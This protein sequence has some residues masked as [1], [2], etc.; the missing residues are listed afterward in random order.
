[1]TWLVSLGTGLIT[2]VLG[3]VALGFLADRWTVWFR[4]SNFEGAAGY[5]VLLYGLVGAVGG[6]IIGVVCSRHVVQGAEAH[7]GRGLGLSVGWVVGIVGCLAVVSYLAADHPPRRDGRRLSLE[8]ELRAPATAVLSDKDGTRPMF[9]LEN[10]RGRTMG[11]GVPATNEVRRV[12]DG[13]EVA[14]V[15]PLDSSSASRTLRV[16]VREGASMTFPLPLPSQPAEADFSWTEWIAPGASWT[17]AGKADASLGEGFRLRCRVAFRAVPPPPPTAEEVGR[18]KAGAEAGALAAVPVDAPLR[19]WLPFTRYGVSE[20][21]QE[22]A[23]ARMRGRSNVVSELGLLMVDEN[24]ELAAEVVRLVPRLGG[25]EGDLKEPLLGAGRDLVTRLERVVDLPVASDPGYEGAAG[26]SVR[27]SAWM[28]AVRHV[29]ERVGGDFSAELR[30]VL[31]LA[32]KRPESH[33]L[34][35]DVVRVASFYLHE[36]TGEAPL[37]TDPPPR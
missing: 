6:G 3:A 23:L 33:A 18:E 12:A 30:A 24:A 7:F 16:A 37:P 2:A 14:M 32:R 34:R 27:F 25:L 8:L 13:W 17:Q 29:R 19:D 9:S 35:Q 22:A 5:F 4:V 11:Y 28:T 21:S 15:L 10:G 31:V 20:A 26:I 36:W 1:M